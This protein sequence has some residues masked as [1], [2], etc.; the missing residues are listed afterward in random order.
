MACSM[1]GNAAAKSKK[2]AP[3]SSE[4]HAL[5]AIASSTSTKLAS[6]LRPEMKPRCV[7]ITLGPMMGSIKCRTAF[8][9]MRLSVF[10][11]DSGRVQSGS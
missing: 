1:E 3:P 5:V 4:V 8:A 7:H 9:K 11:T 6:I 10:V 2:R